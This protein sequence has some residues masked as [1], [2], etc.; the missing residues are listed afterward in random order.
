MTTQPAEP[1]DVEYAGLV[2]RAIAITIDALLINAAALAV[3]GAVFLLE[4]LFSIPQKHNKAVAVIGTVVFVIWLVSYFA[5]FWTTTGQTPGSRVMHIRVTRTNG[6]RLRPRGAL[7]RLAGMAI[8]LPFFW[9]YLPVL[10]NP[11]R[12]A[13]FD[14][15]ARTVVTVAPPELVPPVAAPARGSEPRRDFNLARRGGRP[16]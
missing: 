3:T 10:T 15:L 4:S 14:V 2:T 12:R 7:V 9:G 5:V 11:R 8:S 13:A 16:Q 1:A 6:D